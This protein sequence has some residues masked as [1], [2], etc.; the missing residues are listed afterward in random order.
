MI[1]RCFEIF[2]NWSPSLVIFST[3][4]ENQTP[5]FKV[6]RHVNRAMNRQPPILSSDNAANNDCI[7]PEGKSQ[8]PLW[9]TISVSASSGKTVHLRFLCLVKTIVSWPT[10]NVCWRTV[11]SFFVARFEQRWWLE[12]IFTTCRRLPPWG[13]SGHQVAA[14]WSEAPNELVMSKCDLHL[15]SRFVGLVRYLILDALSSF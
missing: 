13:S 6:D 5:D 2:I 12:G 8:V 9:S 14:G 4:D 11:S 7:Q 1:C 3:A 15:F 10:L